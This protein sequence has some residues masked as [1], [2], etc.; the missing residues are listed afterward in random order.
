MRTF[1]IILLLFFSSYAH[2]KECVKGSFLQD[3]ICDSDFFAYAG[4]EYVGSSAGQPIKSG[5]I[6]GFSVNYNPYDWLGMTVAMNLENTYKIDDFLTFAFI[7]TTHQFNGDWGVKFRAG[8]IKNQF[9]LYNTVLRNPLLRPTIIPPS[10]YV[11]PLRSMFQSTDGI[12]LSLLYKDFELG[13]SIGSPVLIDPE[14]ATLFLTNQ[15]QPQLTNNFGDTQNFYFNWMSN[16]SYWNVR[17]NYNMVRMSPN[18]NG[19]LSVGDINYINFGVEY[20]PATWLFS[21]ELMLINTPE[22][23]WA[24]D[25]KNF[26]K[27]VSIIVGYDINDWWH[28]YANYNY[29]FVTK[30]LERPIPPAGDKNSVF[31]TDISIGTKF[32]YGNLVLGLELHYAEGA[33]FLPFDEQI[34]HNNSRWVYGAAQLFYYW[35]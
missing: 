1:V 21:L 33:A 7:K 30:D 15:A 31:S 2:S 20:D 25:F 19:P 4:Y 11:Q 6:A 18:G 32:Y 12:S 35:N 16:D 10:L 29:V 34:R 23:S 5:P 3:F 9:G 17:A 22:M 27:A 13:Y 8:R 14:S 26:T 28:I 24:N